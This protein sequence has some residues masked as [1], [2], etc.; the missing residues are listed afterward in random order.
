MTG[1]SR[2]LQ[3]AEFVIA[4]EIT[5][6]RVRR[7]DILLRRACLLGELADAINVIQRPD[8]FS[9]LSASLELLERGFDP[10]WH[11]ASRGRSRQE[12]EHEISLGA[13]RGLGSVLCIRGEHRSLDKPDTPKIRDMVRWVREAMPE[14]LIG[15][16]WNPYGAREPALRNLLGKIDAGASYVQT[17]PVLAPEAIG[18]VAEEL[19]SRAPHA[20]IL[21]MLVPLLSSEAA[22][23]LRTRVGIPI[24]ARLSSSLATHGAQAGWAGFS[25]N[26]QR[27]REGGWADGVAVMTLEADPAPDTVAQLLGILGSQP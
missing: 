16:T 12:I 26:L 8:R 10:V 22:G 20:R 27:L 1:F 6:P 14:A 25:E 19:K 21:P 18:P 9:S 5:P 17:Q 24:P 13:E 4:H 2:K 23:R 7:L 11:L 3:R 15:V